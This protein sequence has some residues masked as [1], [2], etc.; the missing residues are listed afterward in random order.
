MARKSDFIRSLNKEQLVNLLKAFNIEGDS[1][2]NVDELRRL[3]SKYVQSNN[4]ELID[5]PDIGIDKTPFL[6]GLSRPHTPTLLLP[7]GNNTEGTGG[8]A[9]TSELTDIM[10]NLMMMHSASLQQMSGSRK[11]SLRDDFVKL[12]H[13][14]QLAFDGKR[15]GSVRIFLQGFEQVVEQIGVADSIALEVLPELFKGEARTW[16]MAFG[17]TVETLESFKELLTAAFVPPA[18]DTQLRKEIQNRTQAM[19]EVIDVYVAKIV[20]SNKLLSSP[21]TENELVNMIL[22]NLSP[23]YICEV[24]K[25]RP[26]TLNDLLV[27]GRV[28]EE[29]CSAQ[30]NY[31]APKSQGVTTD[32]LSVGKPAGKQGSEINVSPVGASF[33]CPEKSPGRSREVSCYKCGKAGHFANRCPGARC[34][35][36]GAQGISTR[37]CSCRRSKTEPGNEEG[38]Q[39][40]QVQGS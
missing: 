5:F 8:N 19:N 20:A 12:C 6:E 16:F 34:F 10:K 22:G 3:I 9:P 11:T 17:N 30:S 13:R 23:L 38:P 27:A 1:W 33:A 15:D 37:L 39:Q 31:V 21:M 4:I 28:V 32:L 36:C 24:I 18:Y 35:H 25:A 2:M 14:R 40:G 7:P 26:K 29:I